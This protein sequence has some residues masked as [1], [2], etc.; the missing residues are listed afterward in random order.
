[1]IFLSS[2]YSSRYH[3]INNQLRTSSNPITQATIQNGQVTVQNVQGRQSHCYA[4][5]A[6]KNQ[7][8]G[9]RVVNTVG[10]AR[11]NQPRVIK[12]YNCNTEAQEAEVVL[13]DE[14]QDFL[15]GNLEETNDCEDL[16]LQAIVN[17]KADH[18]DAYDSNYDDEAIENAIFMAHLSPIGSINDDTVEPC[19]DSDILYEIFLRTKDEAPEII[20][21]ILKQVQVILNA[22]V[23]Y[24]KPKL[25]YL[26]DFGA[27]CYP[28][29][30]FEDL[31]KLQPKADIG[32]FIGYSPTKKA[33]QIYNK[34]TRQIMEK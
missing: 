5:N 27:L 6:G 16:Q 14:Q 3:P 21:K 31:G 10:K 32:I 20:I 30:D 8:L 9:A 33:Y 13:N 18:V 19:Y 29:N 1:M 12:C 23:R 4:G 28:T 17:F 15:A 2:A 7:A 26:H 24:R 25:K 34:R 22:T 11:T